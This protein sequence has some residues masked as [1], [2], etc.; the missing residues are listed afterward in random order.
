MKMQQI[1]HSMKFKLLGWFSDFLN[2]C[3]TKKYFSSKNVKKMH[4]YKSVSK[5]QNFINKVLLKLIKI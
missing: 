3:S 2:F 5:I 4:N 1:W